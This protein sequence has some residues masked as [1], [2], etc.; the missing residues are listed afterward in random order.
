MI[1]KKCATAAD[2]DYGAARH[3]KDEKCPCQHRPLSP[4][5][6]TRARANQTMRA[7]KISLPGVLT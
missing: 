1:C 4:S 6:R 2:Y 7:I 5:G 3:C